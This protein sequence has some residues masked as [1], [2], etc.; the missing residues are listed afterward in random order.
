MRATVLDAGVPM[1]T[2]STATCTGNCS[3]IDGTGEVVVTAQSTFDPVTL[4]FFSWMGVDGS[5]SLSAT[6][7]M[8]VLT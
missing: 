1:G 3:S 7:K 6:A 4:G 5:I 2:T 8:R